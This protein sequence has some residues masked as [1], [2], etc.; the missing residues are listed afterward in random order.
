MI[1]SSLIEAFKLE[2]PQADRVVLTPAQHAML[3]RELT[4]KEGRPA[5]VYVFSG[6]KVEIAGDATKSG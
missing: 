5:R 4:Q 1:I 2:K 3:C 6:L